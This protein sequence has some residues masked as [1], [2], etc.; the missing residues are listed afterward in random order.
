VTA[1]ILYADADARAALLATQTITN[2]GLQVRYASDAVT[3]QQELSGG[4][5]DVLVV[6]RAIMGTSAL[7]WLTS[8]AQRWPDLP[9]ITVA[10]GATEAESVAVLRAG[11]IG[12]V[13]KPFDPAELLLEVQ[14]GVTTASHGAAVPP[15]QSVPRA[16]ATMASGTPMVGSSPALREV[17]NVIRR[18][19]ASQATVLIR[20]ESGAGKE[21]IARRIHEQGP[22]RAGPFIKVH[23][24]ALPEQLLESELFGHEK[25]AFT[26]ASSRKP[27]RVEIAEG[28]TLFL[29]E[30]GDISAVT[31]V[32]LLRVLQ[33]KEYER[34]GGTRTIR[35]D[36]RFMAATHRPLE[37]MIRRGEFREDLYYRLNVIPIV[38]PPL[39]A[40]PDDIEEL[41]RY[42]CQSLGAQNGKPHLRITDDA[43]A[44]LRLQT[45]PG[46]VRQ[47]QNFVERLVVFAE[48]NEIGVSE[49]WSE[50]GTGVS[51]T[52]T[53]SNGTNLD[54]GT[55]VFE[56]DEVVRRAERKALDRAL[57]KAGGNRT[58][59]ARI[60][61]VSRRTLYNKLMEHELL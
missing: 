45:W 43:L 26:G 7:D 53:T 48:G 59:A 29:D 16:S 5:I 27:G 13:H 18:A 22:R 52:S 49:I 20:G 56:L 11:A 46:N 1:T 2:A 9:I 58:V 34:V 14:H 35:A 23:C 61:G 47:L 8:A 54:F 33:D 10:A 36:V 24:A 6:D 28:G 25:G 31:Q 38:A 37:D 21:V 39:R 3:L 51:G 60:L 19:A 41:V 55:S 50:L 15:P 32:K 12:F 42:F 44:L 17:A 57:Q 4:A 30:I 40:R